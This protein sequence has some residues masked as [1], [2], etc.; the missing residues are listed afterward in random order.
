[1][2]KI[3]DVLKT[4]KVLVSDG[5]WGTFLYEK[6]MKAGECPDSWSV[7][8]F[9]DVV[10]IAKKYADA[11]ADMVES[12]SFGASYYKLEHF[13][14]QDKASEI[15]EAAAKASRKGAGKDKFVIASIGPT[16]KLLVSEEV[17]EEE[18]YNAF[19][20]QAIALEKGGADAVCIETMSD[21]DEARCAIKATKE[22][23]KLEIIT[24]FSFDKT[25]QGTYRT[26]MGLS[27]EDSVKYAIEAGS[28]IVGTNCGNGIERMI[29]IVRVM[30][31][32]NPK[33]YILVHA[34]A[35]LPINVDGKDTF[36][37]TPEMMAANVGGLIEAGVNIVGGCCGTTPAHIA[38]IKKVVTDYNV[39]HVK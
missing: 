3:V 37:E 12:N 19:K 8:R 36:P 2:G 28:D 16:G 9:D 22:N 4:G 21:A 33:A 25:I 29:E 34:N 23:T 13:G 31:K 15:N 20:V 6:G 1:M 38:A 24:T 27:P 7:D 14:L 18:L 11:G 32:S 35:G 26:M 5:A 10:D 17:T 30:K 39:K